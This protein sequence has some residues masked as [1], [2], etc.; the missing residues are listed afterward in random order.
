MAAF[1]AMIGRLIDFCKVYLQLWFFYL[2]QFI[3]FYVNYLALKFS[4]E[5]LNYDQRGLGGDGLTGWIFSCLG[6]EEITQGDILAG[7]IAIIMGFALKKVISDLHTAYRIYIERIEYARINDQANV[8]LANKMMIQKIIYTS[9][10]FIPVSIACYYDMSLFR[11]R[12]VYWLLSNEAENT[13]LTMKNWGTILQENRDLFAIS[14]TQLGAYA[15][16]AL[17]GCM[18]ILLEQKTL[19]L[20]DAR[21]NKNVAFDYWFE[22][23]TGGST[24]HN[25]M[26]A[27]PAYTSDNGTE[28]NQT[29]NEPFAAEKGSENTDGRQQRANATNESRSSASTE[30]TTRS[31]S[32]EYEWPNE[33]RTEEHFSYQHH[34]TEEEELVTVFGGA[35]GEKV[36]FSE[37]VNNP[38]KYYIDEARRVWRKTATNNSENQEQAQAA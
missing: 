8:E 18:A 9:I 2:L 26:S 23:I 14:I 16:L 1:N 4:F 10:L 6:V 29:V 37:A 30:D 22:E 38:D 20:R 27:G 5:Q 12:C 21:V 7:F 25:Q 36:A 19:E 24:V 13:V 15:Y 35:P 31:S 11:F 32:E 28:Q 3:L 33:P 34:A 17:I